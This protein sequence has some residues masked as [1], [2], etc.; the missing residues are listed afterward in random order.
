MVSDGI[1]ESEEDDIG[2][3]MM[4]NDSVACNWLEMSRMVEWMGQ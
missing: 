1:S 4:S 3:E 2:V